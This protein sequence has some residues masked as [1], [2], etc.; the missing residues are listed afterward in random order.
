M[1][2]HTGQ[3]L[4]EVLPRYDKRE[5]HSTWIAAAPGVVWQALHAVRVRDLPLTNGLVRLRGGPRAWFG[6]PAGDDAA[7]DRPALDSVAPRPLCASPPRE[8][9]LGDI[10]RY[11]PPNPGRPD[12]PRGDLAAFLAFDEPGWSKVAMNFLLTEEGSGTRLSTETR[13]LGTDR[14]ARLAFQPYWLLIRV[15]SGL[16]R[17]DILRAV[18]AEALAATAK[19]GERRS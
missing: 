5:R 19:V 12:I 6:A 9:V 15:G 18:R 13:V 2:M 16:V 11:A 8:L 7:L 1:T 17:Y 14:L 3:S 10:A 4:A